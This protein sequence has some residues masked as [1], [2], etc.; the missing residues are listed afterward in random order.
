MQIFYSATIDEDIISLDAIESGHAVRVLR[1]KLGDM[2]SVVDGEGTLYSAELIDDNHK[3]CLLR[4][5][6]KIENYGKRDYSLHIALAPTKSIDRYEWFLE[7]STEIGCD[8]F[9]PLLCSRSERK[10]VKDERCLKVVVS[11]VKQSLKAFTP[12][13]ASLTSFTTFMKQDFAGC[14]KFIAHCEESSEKVLLRDL[15]TKGDDVVVLIGPEGDFSPQEVA[16]ARE[17]GFVEV[18]LGDSRLRSETAGV[19]VASLLNIVNQ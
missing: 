16:L 13:S 7:K 6:S 9:T 17:Q 10:V 8:S 19:F 2:L 18:S 12:R 14:K 15:V 3:R 5:S 1:K 11:A 4:I